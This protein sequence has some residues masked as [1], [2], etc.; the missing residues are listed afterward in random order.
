MNELAYSYYN[1]NN[2]CDD[3]IF[4]V[5]Y[6]C[7]LGIVSYYT[8]FQINIWW[9][10]HA[11]ALFSSIVFPFHFRALKKSTIRLHTVHAGCVL[12]GLLIPLIPVITAL[13]DSAVDRNNA[14]NT[15]T[16][17]LGFGMVS[18]PPVLC[19]GVDENVTFYSLILPNI[20]L[21]QVGVSILVLSVFFIYKVPIAFY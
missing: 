18:F 7:T 13:A 8:A 15:V 4:L 6:Y 14:N 1:T 3:F 21:V 19:S 11:I 20:L 10:L 17:T 5:C 9:V 2:N 16:G 12:G